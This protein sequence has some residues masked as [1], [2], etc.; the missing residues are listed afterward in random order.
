ML[1][2]VESWYGMECNSAEVKIEICGL[3]DPYDVRG[4]KQ[5]STSSK[6]LDEGRTSEQTRNL[7][8]SND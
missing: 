8:T 3:C 6:R 7:P 1:Q 4:A 5:R 2:L